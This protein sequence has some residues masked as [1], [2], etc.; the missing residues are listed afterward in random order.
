MH[1]QAPSREK[2]ILIHSN[3]YDFVTTS[4]RRNEVLFWTF[5]T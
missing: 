2:K 1:A 4:L 3:T 5:N